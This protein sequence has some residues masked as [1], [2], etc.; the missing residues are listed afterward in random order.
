MVATGTMPAMA[1]EMHAEHATD[2]DKP[3][4]VVA[5]PFHFTFLFSPA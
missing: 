4:P 3:E 5:K 1:K 2:D